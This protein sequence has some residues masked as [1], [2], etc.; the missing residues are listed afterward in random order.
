MY[1]TGFKKANAMNFL[2]RT[3]NLCNDGNCNLQKG[4]QI[5]NNAK[6]YNYAVIIL[7][8]IRPTR[9]QKAR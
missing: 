3:S 8:Y 2:F 4:N 6:S 9:A 7:M 5:L 1:Y